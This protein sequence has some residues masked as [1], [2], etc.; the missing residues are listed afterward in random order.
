[1]GEST[2]S[3]EQQYKYNGKELERM[4]GLNL[5]DYGARFYDPATCRFTT[6]DPHAEKYNNSPYAYCMNNPMSFVDP[7][8]KDGN[9]K[10]FK[11]AM[12]Y[13]NYSAPP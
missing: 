13:R 3:D 1:M 7:N 11:G 6:V 10:V 8:G 5:Y 12:G 9:L 4:R 2:G